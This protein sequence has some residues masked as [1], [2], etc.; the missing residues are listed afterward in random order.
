M[1]VGDVHGQF[2][3]LLNIFNR[4]GFPPFTKYLFLGDYVDRGRFCVE[5]ISLLMALKVN[6]PSSV[7][8]LRGNHEG[9]VM[10]TAY[11]FKTECRESLIK[12]KS[13]TTVGSTRDSWTYSC[14]YLCAPSLINVIS[15]FMAEFLLNLIK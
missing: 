15:Q 13:N 12:V 6:Y 7:Y 8:L 5:V 11:N 1:I 4:F 3:D 9:R 14:V 2:Y 10:T